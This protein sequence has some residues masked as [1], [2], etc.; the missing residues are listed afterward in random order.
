MAVT[1]YEVQPAGIPTRLVLLDTIGY[2]HTD[3]R[4]DQFPATADAAQ[5]SDLV[6]LVMHARNPARQADLDLVRGLR[7]WFAKRLDLKMPP[8]LGVLTHIDL[9]SPAMEWQPP[10]DWQQ[11][12]RLKEQ[13]IAEAVVTVHEQMGE[14]LVGVA[15]V[16]GARDKVYGIN[17]WLLPA[18]AQLLNEAQAVALLRCLREEAD[19]G[20]VRKVFQQ[21]YAAGKQA[22][23][24][25]WQSA[26]KS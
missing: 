26:T 20:K 14:Y 21:L 3:P 7:A 12:Q 9:L 24:L 22:A 6:L 11:P 5:Q 15:P 23:K 4:T 1:R 17:E 18:V 10:Y 16:C 19:T 2:H 8:V 25:L 13:Q